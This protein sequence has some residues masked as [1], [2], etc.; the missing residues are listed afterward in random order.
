MALSPQQ[1]D[2]TKDEQLILEAMFN[3][4]R[5]QEYLWQELSLSMEERYDPAQWKKVFQKRI[6]KIE[7]LD[8][9]NPMAKVELRKRIL[10]QATLSIIALKVLDREMAENTIEPITMND[11]VLNMRPDLIEE[12]LINEGRAYAGLD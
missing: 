9:S 10:Q 5:I 4:R 7:Q 3:G 8:M 6:D 11:D 1:M 12:R 2:L